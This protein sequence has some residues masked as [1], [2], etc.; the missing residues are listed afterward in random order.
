[1]GNCFGKRVKQRSQRTTEQRVDEPKTDAKSPLPNDVCPICRDAINNRSTPNECKHQFC[2]QCLFE[3]SLRS[4]CCPVCRQKFSSILFDFKS[5]IKYSGVSVKYSSNS[6]PIRLVHNQ[7]S[8]RLGTEV[9]STPIRITLSDAL[10]G[11]RLYGEVEIRTPPEG[12]VIV[13]YDQY[14][15]R[16]RIRHLNG[17]RIYIVTNPYPNMKLV[18]PEELTA[19]LTQLMFH[20]N[21]NLWLQ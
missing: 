14:S 13:A 16:F 18:L 10:G 21:T 5:E 2:Y 6:I 20:R 15:D 9:E 1:M 12:Y 8:N 11:F 19:T 7:V 3:W 17:N 4:R